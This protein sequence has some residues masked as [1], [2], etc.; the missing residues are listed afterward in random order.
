MAR[1][2]NKTSHVLH[3]LAGEEPVP[4]TP[5]KEKE[6][7]ETKEPAGTA[8]KEISAEETPTPLESFGQI[9]PEEEMP[10]ISIISTGNSEDDPVADLIKGQLEEDFPEDILTTHP[11]PDTADIPADNGASDTAE[12]AADSSPYNVTDTSADNNSPDTAAAVDSNS[13]DTPD[14]D[15]PGTAAADS[16]A[17]DTADIPIDNDSSTS[18]PAAGSAEPPAQ[19]AEKI[20]DM[21]ADSNAGTP[22]GGSDT[23]G[24]TEQPEPGT[25]AAETP[26]ET[27][28]GASAA[29]Q[30]DSI[31]PDDTAAAVK[32]ADPTDPAAVATP[33]ASPDRPPLAQEHLDSVLYPADGH[34]LPNYRFVNVMEYIVKDIAIDYMKKFDMCTCERCVVD[35]IA[36]TL[37]YC[38]AKYIVVDSHSVSPLLNFYS[39]HYLGDVTVELTKACI[40]IKE[41]PRH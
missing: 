2:S 12:I 11:T 25:Q 32:P 37:T 35:T 3:L 39:N 15:G 7:E 38:S 26:A 33:A 6:T 27:E 9:R 5:E 41:N 14:S 23:V 13:S 4:E 36:L 17:S 1:K 8:E 18:V 31:S 29:V 30:P 24:Q 34:H 10:N 22:A 20:S 19:E 21:P 28:T 16:S 40:K